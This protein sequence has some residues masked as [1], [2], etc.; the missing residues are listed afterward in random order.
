MRWNNG[1]KI[2]ML[3][4]LTVGFMVGSAQAAQIERLPQSEEYDTVVSDT[5]NTIAQELNSWSAK[6]DVAAKVTANDLDWS[7]AYRSYGES[8]DLFGQTDATYAQIQ[9][10]LDYD[11][12]LPVEMDGSAVY[13]T[14]SKAD[15]GK[16]AQWEISGISEDITVTPEDVEKR[17]ST[18]GEQA[19]HMMLIGGTDEQTAHMVVLENK[20]QPPEIVFLS[21]KDSTVN[22][23]VE[24][25]EANETPKKDVLYSF[26]DA[27]AAMQK[28]DSSDAVPETQESAVPW[29]MIAVLGAVIVAVIC[30]AVYRKKK[31]K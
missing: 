30:W 26:S 6:R 20:N 10:E 11:W 28:Q 24:S 1:K 12:V 19:E 14:L 31:T 7:R 13:V 17:L 4:L 27:A 21:E 16:Q 23:E 3:S 22:A 8:G 29:G 9:A 25:L 15:S 5:E 18:A 2:V